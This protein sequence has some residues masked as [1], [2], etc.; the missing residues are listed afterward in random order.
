MAFLALLLWAA[1]L[2][3][4]WHSAFTEAGGAK[5]ELHLALQVEGGKVT[6]EVETPTRNAPLVEGRLTANGFS[7]IAQSIW[8]AQLARRPI[9]G[10]LRDG[11]LHVEVQAWPD[12]PMAK[13]EMRRISRESAIPKQ[14]PVPPPQVKDLPY[15]GLARTP[16]MG[17]SSWNRFGCRVSDPMIR[18]MADAMVSSGMK[19]A[20][21][22]YINIDD[23]WQGERDAQ[24]NIQSDPQRFPDMKALVD[25]VHSKGLKIGI[26]SSPGPRTCAGYEGSYGHEEQDARTYA[27][28]GFDYL[29]YDWCSAGKLYTY[30]QMRPIFQ[31][32]GEALQSTG[33]PIVY[34]ISQYGIDEVWKWG[35]KA[36][37]HL[38]RTTG[39]IGANWKAVEEIGFEKQLGLAPYAGPGGWNDPDMLEV[40][41]GNMSLDEYRSHMSLW[42]LLAA[43]LIAGN[44]L[45]TMTP[46][47]KGILT[48]PGVIAMNQD[49]LGRQATRVWKRDEMEV[50]AKPLSDG[51]VA[52]G[53]FNRGETKQTV[54]MNWTELGM[55]AAPQS[56]TDI[57]NGTESDALP[58]LSVSVVSHGVV[59]LRVIE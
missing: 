51:S 40:G 27:A 6:G 58:T 25:Y 30:E 16:P 20:G 5:R 42:A 52:V 57:W 33:K 22:T 48:H 38:W 13:Y 7:A 47:I 59:L 46:E 34:S 9:H 10:E 23:C 54:S 37:A 26:Y 32:M 17:W 19:A 45:R 41:N 53:I 49:P 43:P 8:D 28:W 29:K 12:G 3:G 2:T 35:R 56:V 14:T 24:G 55:K 50:W 21:Y 1:D 18:E 39:D 11:K 44:D 4:L 36:G 31:K 15:N